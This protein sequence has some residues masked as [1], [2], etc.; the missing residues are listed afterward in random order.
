MNAQIAQLSSELSAA[1]HCHEA[2]F[3]EAMM[4]ERFDKFDAFPS[5]DLVYQNIGF[6]PKGIDMG[7]NFNMYPMD[8]NL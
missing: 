6:F 3:N 1:R 4:S 2:G 5:T 8:D 7:P